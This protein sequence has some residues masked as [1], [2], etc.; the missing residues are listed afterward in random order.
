MY[1][2]H[3]GLLQEPFS[4][5]P[6]PAFLFM[7][8]AHNEALAHLMY[9]FSHGGFVMI[10]GEVGT[11][12]TTLL[13]NLL[14]RTPPELDVAFILNP[15]LTVRELLETLCDDLGVTYGSGTQSVKHYIDVL[16]QH[17]LRTH[18]AG[19]STVVIIDEAQNLS[20]AV[21]EQIRL[22]T[23]LETND[24]KLLR[25][26]L[27]GQPELA[28]MLARTELRQLAQRITAR[29][30]L[31]SLSKQEVA[32]YVSHRLVRARGNPNL[33][34]KGAIKTLYRLSKGTPRL[35]NVIAD[36]SML[37]AYVEGKQQVTASF[38]RKGAQE[39]LGKKHSPKWLYR[40]IAGAGVA[41]LL[42]SL[43]LWTYDRR[44]LETVTATA[45]ADDPGI[46]DE[47][48]VQPANTPPQPNLEIPDQTE[49]RPAAPKPTEASLDL[50]E[51]LRQP[52]A[53]RG[54][55]YEAMFNLWGTTYDS[56]TNP[57]ACD[58]APQ[59]GLQ[60]LRQKGSWS[61]IN[62]LNTPVILE[63][64]GEGA[65]PYYMTITQRDGTNYRAVIGT[66]TV[67]VKPKDLRNAWSGAYVLLWQTPPNYIGSL[68]AGDNHVSVRW[69]QARLGELI[70]EAGLGA[71][72][73]YFTDALRDALVTFQDQ[74][75]LL[76]D[77]IAGPLTLIHLSDRLDLPAPKLSP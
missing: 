32:A 19:R 51:Y 33:F 13:R 28:E 68:R 59:V 54:S 71:P 45:I 31:T 24:K 36:R 57:R 49:T 46:I 35:I 26:I 11:G 2:N 44:P 74:E 29:Y 39:V 42:L 40:S 48:A 30:H 22:L 17:L 47:S 63:L 41:A 8:D 73:T 9:G 65:S 70:P 16:N 60:C 10:T 25:I 64:W 27:L 3:F 14:D 66:Q 43:F 23:N 50:E 15:R 4:I 38:V 37:G 55:A 12:K 75:G 20:P 72:N 21:L 67:T 58:F 53:T 1:Q 7:S 76:T 56:T 62:A 6:D 52:V 34:T 69:L 77:G 61:E 5:A 18:Q